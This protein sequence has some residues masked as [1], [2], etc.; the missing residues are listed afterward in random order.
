MK[1]KTKNIVIIAMFGLILFGF[2]LL[3]LIL[4][5]KD[6]SYDER[7]KLQQFPEITF[8]NIENTNFMKDFEKY[9]LDQFAFRD[10]FRSI[11]AFWL[12]NVF[13]QKDN[14][15][16][17]EVGGNVSKI[18]YP[19]NEKSIVNAAKKFNELMQ[20]H[21]P[22]SNVFYSIIPDKNYY[23]AEQNGFLDL[24]Y[25]KMV[26]IMAEGMDKDIKYINIFDEID[27]NSYYNTDHHWSQDK[28]LGVANK[29][30]TEMGFIDAIKGIEYTNNTIEGFKGVYGGQYP[31]PLDSENLVYLTSELMKNWTVEILDNQGQMVEKPIYDE[32]LFTSVD[33]YNVFLQGATPIVRITNGNNPEGKELFIFRDSFSSSLTPLLVEGYSKVTLIDLRYMSSAQFEMLDSNGNKLVD[34]GTGNDVLFMYGSAVLNNSSMLRK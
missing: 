23:M 4:P 14:N 22:D 16:V 8:E 2:F 34:F 24:D 33:P 26:S 25:D 10:G 12:Y 13:N 3:N 18:Q 7:R 31:L 28:I 20:N 1:D 19:L 9:T 11:K 5:D 27:Q 29:L 30:A 17:Y 15:G 32:S 21:F 6:M